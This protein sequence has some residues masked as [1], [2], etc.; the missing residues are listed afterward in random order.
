MTDN[1]DHRVDNSL[2]GGREAPSTRI[3][4]IEKT[5]HII[6]PYY[7]ILYTIQIKYRYLRY[8][9]Y[10]PRYNLCSFS[11]PPLPSHLRYII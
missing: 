11:L 2:A 8:K 4:L 1:I 9:Q 6:R 3:K 10:E 5:A 7:M